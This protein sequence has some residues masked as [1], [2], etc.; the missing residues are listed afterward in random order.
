MHHVSSLLGSHPGAAA[1]DRDALATCVAACFACAQAC[2]ACAD[3]CLG[4]GEVQRLV[5]CIRLNLDCA[6]VCDAT[7]RMLSRQTGGDTDLRRVQLEACRVACRAC[8]VECERHAD[9][10]EHCRIC[11]EVCRRC[12]LACARVLEAG[13]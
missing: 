10:M 11:A 1:A 2:T 5:G 3:A 13:S 6:D 8:A 7:G 4:E 9:H 12:E